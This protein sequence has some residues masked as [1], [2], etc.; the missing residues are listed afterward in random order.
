MLGA[1][2]VGVVAA[3][4][5]S[6]EVAAQALPFQVHIYSG[7][8]TTGDAPAPDGSSV[9]ANILE[10]SSQPVV[11]KDGKYAALSIL[12]PDASHLNKT[13]TFKL[14]GVVV[15]AQTDVFKAAGVPVSKRNFDLT[16]PALPEPTATATATPTPTPPVALP[17]VYSGL[18]I[19]AG[20]SAPED[21]RLVARIG[22]Y[23][24]IP[25]VID[26]DV[27]SNLVVDPGDIG[28]VGQTVEFYL[29]DVKSRN[30]GTYQSGATVKDFD[31]VFVGLPTPTP[32]LT[33]TPVPPTPT[34]T[35]TPVPTATRTPT[36]SPTP[37]PTASPTVSMEPTR[38][39][40]ATLT[41][42]PTVIRTDTPT[43]T[44]V[45]TATHTP[46]ASPVPAP[47]LPPPPLPTAAPAA[48][49]T[50]GGCFAADH[51]PLSTAVANLLMMGAPLGL[52][53]GVKR[54]GRGRNRR[55]R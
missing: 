11:V 32:T 16:F 13:V 46:T 44:S 26:G 33:A 52:I 18:L 14:N 15:A 8:A 40:F 42:T 23:E 24:S 50:G 54:A 25:A 37:T 9:T 43:P 45:P 38:V 28:V 2:L 41:P 22:E 6:G 53:A 21:A 17:S 5:P 10:F 51:V 48:Q 1:V 29:N 49:E 34:P 27:Y 20:G 19:V 47:P 12:P 35:R 4:A 55:P 39:P 3:T 36:P 7:K 31:L 30:T